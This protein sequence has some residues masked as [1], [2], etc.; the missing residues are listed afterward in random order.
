MPDAVTVR[1]GALAAAS[2]GLQAARSSLL[3]DTGH[4]GG[5]F[6]RMHETVARQMVDEFEKMGMVVHAAGR[7]S[8]G[9]SILAL[10]ASISP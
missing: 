4:A 10:S 6:V 1:F 9:F 5:I 2:I 7:S 8:D 3:H